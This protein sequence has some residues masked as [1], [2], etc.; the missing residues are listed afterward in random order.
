MYNLQYNLQ[1]VHNRIQLQYNL[2][3]NFIEF[4]NYYIASSMS[5]Q[6]EPNRTLQLATW[7]GKMKLSCPAWDYL[8]YPARK[9]S[10]KA[11]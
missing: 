7:V 9:I 10:P 1:L 5:G 3:Y 2:Q 11:I 4:P 8:L 6:D